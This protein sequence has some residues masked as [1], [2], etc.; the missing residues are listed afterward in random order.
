M[1]VNTAI[2]MV[3][4]GKHLNSFID[5]NVLHIFQPHQQTDNSTTRKYGGTGLGLAISKRLVEQMNGEIGIESEEGKGTTF[6]FT[7][8]KA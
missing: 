7:L 3:L 8:K 5:K 2:N 1:P 4:Q 6:Y